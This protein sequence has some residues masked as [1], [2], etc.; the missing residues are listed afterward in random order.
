MLYP[1]SD[2]S[3]ITHEE[4]SD[5]YCTYNCTDWPFAQCKV[6]WISNRYLIR[7]KLTGIWLQ[8]KHTENKGKSMSATCGNPYTDK[9]KQKIYKTYPK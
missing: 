7:S 3:S 9:T 6:N 4:V 2:S 8:M 5:G 1:S